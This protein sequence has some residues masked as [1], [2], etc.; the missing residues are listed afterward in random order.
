[1]ATQIKFLNPD[2][3]TAGC[4]RQIDQK[5]LVQSDNY[6]LSERYYA[7]LNITTKL[8]MLFYLISRAVPHTSC[9]HVIGELARF[10]QLRLHAQP[11]DPLTASTNQHRR[12]L[13]HMALQPSADEHVPNL[14]ISGT[15]SVPPPLRQGGQGGGR[16]VARQPRS[17]RGVTPCR[18]DTRTPRAYQR[19]RHVC[20]RRPQRAD[21][22][23]STCAPAA[24]R[25]PTF[26]SPV[27]RLVQ[28]SH[29][30]YEKCHTC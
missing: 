15:A 27:C 2:V 16:Q 12:H 19:H 25:E 1:M 4:L 8:L 6:T 30:P 22:L 23:L 13:Q 26:S 10:W 14:L 3:S 24:P 29:K 17:R 21:S 11:R 5:C 20:S 7:E 28:N 9:N 18:G